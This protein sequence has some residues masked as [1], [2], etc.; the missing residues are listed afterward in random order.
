MLGNQ[1][2]LYLVGWVIQCDS[3]AETSMKVSRESKI[4]LAAFLSLWFSG[5]IRTDEALAQS[6]EELARFVRSKSTQQ[7]ITHSS[8]R[9]PS[10]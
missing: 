8:V 3:R 1:Q 10:L 4:K 9:N 5:A 6:L 2:R 7:S